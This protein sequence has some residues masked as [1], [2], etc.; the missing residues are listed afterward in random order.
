MTNATRSI[1]A[2]SHAIIDYV[3]VVLMLL[4]PSV[5][6]FA[7]RQ[8]TWM[9]VF[10]VVLLIT[11]LLTRYPFGAMK[12]IAFPAHGG[13]EVLLGVLLLVLPWM[14]QFARGIKSRNFYVAMGV[15]LL[16]V[17]VLTDY[18]GRRVGR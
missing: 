2:W 5:A 3:I 15:M 8:A 11:S 4:G 9:Y 10:G 12:A 18:R 1:G 16:L 17:A 14:A 13:I 6:G 7:G